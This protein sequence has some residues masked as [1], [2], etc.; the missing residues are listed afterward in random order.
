MCDLCLEIF[1]VDI[2]KHPEKMQCEVLV[3][4]QQ[5]V[6]LMIGWPTWSFAEISLAAL[7]KL[8]KSSL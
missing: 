4:D 1:S 7:H 5:S 2:K 3:R 8:C 6:D